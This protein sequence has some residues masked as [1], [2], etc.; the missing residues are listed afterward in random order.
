MLNPATTRL[1]FP[2]IMAALGGTLLLVISAA[3]WF[4]HQNTNLIEG[5]LYREG[6]LVA[7][8]LANAVAPDLVHKNY[9][10]IEAR[11]LQTAS[12]QHVRSALVIDMQ[13]QVLSYVIRSSDDKPAHP[14]FG[15][16]HV[17]PPLTTD[18][19][20]EELHPDFLSVWHIVKVGVDIGWV[21]I[22]IESDY[23][24]HSMNEMRRDVWVLALIVAVLGVVSLGAAIQRSLH[25][26]SL[27]ETEVEQT[28]HRLENKAYYD[29]L[30]HLP[31]R[32]LMF[33]RLRQAISRNARSRRQLAVCFADLDNFKQINDRFG[34]N[35]GDRVLLEVAQRLSGSI[36]SDDTVARLGGDE[37]VIL[38]NELENERNAEM[39]VKRLLDS[40]MEPLAI[41]EREID[42][43]GSI[44]YALYP[45]DS[46][47]AD[48]L[49]A[50]AD[51]AMYQI[52]SIGGSNTLRSRSAAA[53]NEKMEI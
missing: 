18:R 27:R 52:K 12:S 3:L 16:R 38:L 7:E 20:V 25:L 35:V 42:I 5:H 51:R 48:E 11:L 17:A 19:S 24:I 34:H 30:T 29:S 37:F 39:A 26:L 9:G 36:R 28:K 47:D 14:D 50:L 4:I 41:E 21:R 6:N 53:P 22:E 8:G 32:S 44:G 49:I 23:S 15:L 45:D 2:V 10:G 1:M 33:D 13:G 31:N 43:K 46:E 40:L